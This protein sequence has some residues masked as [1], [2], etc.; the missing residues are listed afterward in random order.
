MF[1]HLST[2]NKDGDIDPQEILRDNLPILNLQGFLM[3]FD[4]LLAE[5]LP[6]RLIENFMSS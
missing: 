5:I 1:E 2:L 4:D 3:A 6:E